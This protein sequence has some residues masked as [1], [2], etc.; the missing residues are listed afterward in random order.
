M[1]RSLPPEVQNACAALQQK[2]CIREEELE[3]PGLLS[4]DALLQCVVQCSASWQPKPYL[5]LLLLYGG[6]GGAA[7]KMQEWRVHA[8]SLDMINDPSEDILCIK[9]CLL[10]TY[11]V[12]CVVRYG[13]VWMSPACRSW[14][15]YMSRSTYGRTSDEAG[16]WGNDYM[17]ECKQGNDC[18]LITAYLMFLCS[19]QVVF[20]ALEQPMNSLLFKFPCIAQ[21]LQGD[22]AHRV[23]CHAGA[24]GASTVKALEIHYTWPEKYGLERLA[25]SRKDAWNVFESNGTTPKQLAEIKGKWKCGNKLMPA[26]AEYP[27]ALC[28]IIADVAFKVLLDFGFAWEVCM[29]DVHGS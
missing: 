7:K 1:K 29:D 28:E 12:K 10:T 17:N 24:L 3:T 21:V 23:V 25:F 18:A 15:C 5:N 27:P 13:T 4:V 26:S 22:R 6:Q 11:M 8:D 20:Y 2:L 14:L 9:G 19:T 16:I